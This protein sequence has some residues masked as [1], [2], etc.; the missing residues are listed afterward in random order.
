[1]ECSLNQASI[2]WNSLSESDKEKI[3]FE[4]FPNMKIDD[5]QDLIDTFKLLNF[6]A[7]GDKQKDKVRKTMNK[8]GLC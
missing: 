2:V 7:L 6:S 1:M 3:L 4:A 8:L 5:L